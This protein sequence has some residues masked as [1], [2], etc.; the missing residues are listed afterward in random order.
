MPTCRAVSALAT[1]SAANTNP[2][3][4]RIF[5]YGNDSDLAIRSNAARCSTDISNGGA[6]DTGLPPTLNT[7]TTKP[8]DH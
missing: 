8:T 2:L 3:A 4:W 7:P 5:R 6:T 1:P